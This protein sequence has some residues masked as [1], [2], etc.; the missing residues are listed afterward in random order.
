MRH[1]EP[2]IPNP[3]PSAEATADNQEQPN[4]DEGDKR[5]V[6]NQH[7]VS[8]DAKNCAAVHFLCR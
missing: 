6:C 4:C 7:S 3:I 5:D 8:N 2:R 1:P